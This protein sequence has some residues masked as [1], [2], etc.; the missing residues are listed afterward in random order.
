M[1]EQENFECFAIPPHVWIEADGTIAQEPAGWSR[2][3]WVYRE[4]A[5]HLGAEAMP[6]PP[7]E[8]SYPPMLKLVSGTK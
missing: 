2:R 5:F 4:A 3:S 8:P 6:S 1:D 7:L